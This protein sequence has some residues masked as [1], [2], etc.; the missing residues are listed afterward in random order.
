MITAR[1]LAHFEGRLARIDARERSMEPRPLL[2]VHAKSLGFRG[3]VPFDRADLSAPPG[4]R[5][6]RPYAQSPWVMR[7]IQIKAGEVSSVP[8]KFFAGDSEYKSPEFDAFWAAPFLAPGGR[9][10][11]LGEGQSQLIGWLDLRGE[12]FVLKGDD[13]L[14]PHQDVRAGRWSPLLIARPDRMRPVFSGADLVGWSF[15]DPSGTSHA[16][17]P[18]QVERIALWNPYSDFAALAPV[19]AI[20]N[21]AESDYLAGVYVRNLMR[22]NGDQGVYV[23]A[24]GG[25]PT[26][27]QQEQITTM[28]RAKR[29]AASRGDFRPVFLTGDI[30]IEDAKAQAPDANLN[31][32]RLLD[33][34]TVFIGLGVP[35][36]MA[37][38][39]S[40]YSIGSDSDR[41]RLITG[42]CMPLAK[43]VNRPF[44]EIGSR[45]AGRTLSAESDWDE[46]P[47]VQEVRRARLQSAQALWDKGWS[48]KAINEY[49]DLGMEPF[50]G[51]DIAYL[52]FSVVPVELGAARRETV[53]AD[54][55]S[56]PDFA[57]ETE[58][59]KAMGR[60]ERT[61]LAG[62]PA[63]RA[64]RREAAADPFAMFHCTCEHGQ[65]VAAALTPRELAQ[66]RTL[67]TKRRATVKS[68]ASAFGR[69]LTQARVETLRNIANNFEATTLARSRGDVVATKAAAADF[70]F[71][72][73]KFGES[74]QAA[75]RNQGKSA[76]QTAGQQLLAELAKDDPFVYP[77]EE[78][79]DYLARRENK[80]ANTPT[81]IFE[82]IKATLE[83]GFVAGD[84]QDELASR[85]RAAFNG[86]DA[87]R[88]RRI[89]LTETAAAYGAGRAQAMDQA[90]VQYK[91]WLSSGGDNV[92][93]AHAAANGQVV[94]VHEH[95]IVD[96][97]PLEFPGDDS[98][99]P[100]NIINCHCVSVAVAGPEEGDT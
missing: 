44:A 53:P 46:H 8:V 40:S 47:V 9:R 75:M 17:L 18:E 26:D 29:A 65:V 78:V 55:A 10:L 41:F 33:R 22:N 6:S 56:D 57:E 83:E 5:L 7:A 16:L 36:S 37:D 76:L 86:I 1:E 58:F 77:P 91:K 72:L 19:E 50:P 30:E 14:A 69:V 100:G 31:A 2:K 64:V 63:C 85:V 60:A 94:P 79:L 84:T 67:M 24:K 45:M 23:I 43:V 66:W 48:W 81:S 39:Q 88:A 52:P 11:S 71:D 27:A 80:L 95:F 70:L 74:F 32:T 4:E 93:A 90:G 73:V 34:H 59:E 20:M 68:Y 21:A 42:T 96:G 51:W 3:A 54:P 98:G 99:S 87:T 28:L 61:L 62:R 35:A 25:A 92:R 12:C 82:E 49:L 38:V 89:A 97:E 15:T 13:W